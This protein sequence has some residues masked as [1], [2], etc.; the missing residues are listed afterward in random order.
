[1][2]TTVGVTIADPFDPEVLRDVTP[3]EL[4]WPPE[5]VYLER[6]TEWLDPDR[7]R[8]GE[9]RVDAFAALDSQ[10]NRFKGEPATS[11]A[12]RAARP[13]IST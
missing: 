3:G 1:M 11:E 8:G 5:R 2:A 4:S 9:Q 12:S 10:G 13:P 6:P 7:E